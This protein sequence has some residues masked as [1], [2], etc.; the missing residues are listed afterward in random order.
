LEER[1]VESRRPPPTTLELPRPHEAQIDPKKLTEY[2]LSAD[3]ETGKH[4]ARGF[5]SALG[6]EQGDWEYLRDRILE[7]LPDGE[8][9]SVEPSRWGYRYRVT[10]WID[11]LNGESHPVATRWIVEEGAPPRF[12]SAWVDDL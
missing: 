1:H 12:T 11:G 9:K 8:V 2:V 5:R 3:H 4:K 10:L 6:I 7:C